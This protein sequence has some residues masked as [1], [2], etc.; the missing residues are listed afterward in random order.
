MQ[1]WLRAFV[2]TCALELPV[3][4]LFLRTRFAAWWAP[5]V[6]ALA[7]QAATHPALWYA[8]PRFAPYEA[9]L[10]V[11]ESLVTLTEAALVWIVLTVRAA[12]GPRAVIAPSPFRLARLP[13]GARDARASIALASS[14]TANAFSTLAGL[15][16][17]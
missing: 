5:V 2:W 7:L 15:L 13:L 8:M 4:V 10:V 12:R 1:E 11:A 16:F 6:L 17:Y 14:L 3:Y 9:W